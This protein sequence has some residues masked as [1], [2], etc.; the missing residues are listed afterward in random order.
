[1]SQLESKMQ[2]VEDLLVDDKD[3]Q[4]AM[5]K[6]QLEQRRQRRHKLSEKL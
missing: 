3:R 1:M 4:A 2:R 6:H 5:L